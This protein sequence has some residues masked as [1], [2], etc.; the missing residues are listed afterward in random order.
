[1]S[2]PYAVQGDPE[3]SRSAVSPELDLTI[4]EA[5]Y[6]GQLSGSRVISTGGKGD[7]GT[8]AGAAE[9]SPTH[10]TRLSNTLRVAMLGIMDLQF[11]FACRR[12]MCS[13]TW[14]K[15]ASGRVGA[16]GLRAGVHAGMPHHSLRGS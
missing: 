11:R 10:A 13:G 9:T 14:Y 6:P 2:S 3:S 1:M 5:V 12:N 15:Y 8:G 16:N 4:F 7:V